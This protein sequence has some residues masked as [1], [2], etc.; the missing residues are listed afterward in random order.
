MTESVTAFLAGEGARVGLHAKAML[1][2]EVFARA[3]NLP[4]GAVPGVFL[5]ARTAGW[6]AHILE[7]YTSE[8]PLRPRA[9]FVSDRSRIGRYS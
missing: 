5:L 1:G 2:L 8:T 4:R 7:Q 3:L 6:V 9:K